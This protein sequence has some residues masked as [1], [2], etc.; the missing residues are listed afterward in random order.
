M[1][2][3]L[4]FFYEALSSERHCIVQNISY[5]TYLLLSFVFQFDMV[6]T[7]SYDANWTKCINMYKYQFE[8]VST[9]KMYLFD[10][11]L[12]TSSGANRAKSINQIFFS[13]VPC[14]QRQQ[15]QTNFSFSEAIQHFFLHYISSIIS[16]AKRCS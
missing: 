1:C 6:L 15:Q 9:F 13:T 16:I 11:S 14:Q 2:I 5:S 3:F 12:Q 7:F 4:K 10:L 8:N